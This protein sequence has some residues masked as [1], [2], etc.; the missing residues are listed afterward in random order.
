VLDLDTRHLKV[1]ADAELVLDP[2]LALGNE[3]APHADL[4]RPRK[5]F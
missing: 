2:H 1:L 5:K 3:V 4:V